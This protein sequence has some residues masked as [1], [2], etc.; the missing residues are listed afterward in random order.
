MQSEI[1][2][3]D[4][5]RAKHRDENETNKAKIETKK[6]SEKQCFTVRN[7]FTKEKL[8]DKS[9]RRQVC[10]EAHHEEV[11]GRELRGQGNV[12]WNT[13]LIETKK[14]ENCTCQ[15]AQGLYS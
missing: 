12:E 8:Q 5:E 13:D 15:V 9:P 7:I 6:G 11:Q 10:V 14:F 3:K 4:Q 1:D 2:W